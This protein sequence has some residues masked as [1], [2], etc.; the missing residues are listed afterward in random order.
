MGVVGSR[1]AIALPRCW[2]GV[3]AVWNGELVGSVVWCAVVG[4]FEADGRSGRNGEAGVHA[5]PYIGLAVWRG[6]TAMGEG[7]RAERSWK[8]GSVSLFGDVVFGADVGVGVGRVDVVDRIGS[9]RFPE[10]S[11]FSVRMY[12]SGPGVCTSTCVWCVCAMPSSSLSPG[13]Y[14]KETRRVAKNRAR[15]E[16]LGEDQEITQLVKKKKNVREKKIKASLSSMREY[17]VHDRANP[18]LGNI[19]VTQDTGKKKKGENRSTS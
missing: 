6:A 9:G 18:T 11:A 17:W 14:P 10:L 2:K 13:F 8:A 1:A 12:T 5:W 4:I 7:T 15:S 3:R 19:E 16:N